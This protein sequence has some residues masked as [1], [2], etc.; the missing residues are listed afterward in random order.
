MAAKQW[1][2]QLGNPDMRTPIA[3][4]LAWPESI[5]SGV[6][7]LDLA[8][9]GRLDFS[10]ADFDHFPCLAL[11]YRALNAGGTSTAIL[12]AANE[13]AVSAFLD[14]RLKFTDIAV[15]ISEVLENIVPQAGESLDEIVADDAQA[16]E[17]ARQLI[18]QQ[19]Q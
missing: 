19:Q 15:V 4:A 7:P 8:A 6:A 13:E 9:A 14:K 12:N 17:L 16:R 1:L 3:N 11:A 2:A 10:A 5:D 18:S